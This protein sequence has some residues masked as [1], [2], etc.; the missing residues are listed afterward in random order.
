MKSNI[1]TYAFSGLPPSV[2]YQVFN[3]GSVV[4]ARTNTGPQGTFSFQ[5]TLDGLRDLMIVPL[6]GSIFFI[7]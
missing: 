4:V 7:Q 1:A 3:N 2:D 5:A 6:Q